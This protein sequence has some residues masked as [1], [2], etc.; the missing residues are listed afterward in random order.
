MSVSAV[1]FALAFSVISDVCYDDSH[2]KD[3]VGDLY[4]P[5][6]VLKS[7]PMVLI[8]HG[9]SWTGLDRGATKG[10]ADY[11][12]KDLG[13]AAFNIEY[14]LA[15]VKNRWPACGNDCVAAANFVLTNGFKSKYGFAYDKVWICG[16]SAGG[17]LALWTLVTLDKSKVAGAIAISPIGNPD[18]D[19]CGNRAG[20][21][22]LLGSG[23][24]YDSMD[25][26]RLVTAGQAPL[27]ITHAT[28]DHVVPISSSRSFANAYSSVGNSVEFFEYPND[29]EPNEAGH[30]IWRPS[31]LPHRLIDTLE[32]KIALFIRNIDSCQDRRCWKDEET[33][34]AKRRDEK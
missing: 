14:R 29:I 31:S 33:C 8:I 11:F 24:D 17:H 22:A 28:D 9:G 34:P 4:L 21:Q 7:T 15:S 12:A 20:Q 6:Q 26:R 3:C 19:V 16:G 30:C 2:R 1:V 10:I 23:M 25:P 32:R 13:F 5:K 18:C 27:L